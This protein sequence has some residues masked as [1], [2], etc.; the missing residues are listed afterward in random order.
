MGLSSKDVGKVGFSVDISG[1][2][3]TDS[4]DSFM[5]KFPLHDY[6]W[7]QPMEDTTEM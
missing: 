6:L 5:Q 4:K 1:I 3:M 7:Y 2:Y